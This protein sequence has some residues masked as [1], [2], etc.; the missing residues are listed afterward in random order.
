VHRNTVTV[1]PEQSGGSSKALM[2]ESDSSRTGSSSATFHIPEEAFQNRIEIARPFPERRVPEPGKAMTAS[3]PQIGIAKRIKVIELD[4]AIL[5][6]VDHGKRNRICLHGLSL[7]DAQSGAR[8]LE[9]QLAGTAPK[10]AGLGALAVISG[11][12]CRTETMFKS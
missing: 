11:P 2:D 10:M 3:F 6:A 5:A 7:I 8:R 12:A 9:Q 4:E 1:I